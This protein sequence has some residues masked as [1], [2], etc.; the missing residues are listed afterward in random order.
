MP[1][2]IINKILHPI[3]A[4]LTRFPSV[5]IRR[6]LRLLNH[7]N[8]NK[9]FDVGASTGS[10]AMHMK[11]LRFNGTII[12]FEPMSHSFEQLKKN[13]DKYK[14][15]I[16]QNYALGDVEQETYINVSG[17]SDSSSL[18]EILPNHV[19]SEPTSKIVKKEKIK[20]KTLDS[21][22]HDF[23]EE[24]DNVLLKLDTQGFEKQVLDG[25]KKS[26]PLIKGIQLEMSLVPLYEDSMLFSEMKNFLIS[27]GFKLFSLENGF[28]DSQ[29]GQLLQV[30][31]IFFK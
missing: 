21:I 2:K 24:N 15:W 26:L 6:R 30:D 16:T 23:Y 22:F 12:S 31:G 1:I 18:L 4:Q 29:T 9:I 28:F 7:F 25:S 10:Y 17:N 5:D 13:A 3:G 20:V 19:Q 8:I 14:N 27:K 11:D